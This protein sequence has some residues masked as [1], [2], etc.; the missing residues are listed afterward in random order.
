MTVLTFP[1][2]TATWCPVCHLHLLQWNGRPVQRIQGVK[3]VVHSITTIPQD[4]SWKA[5]FLINNYS[6]SYTSVSKI[7]DQDGIDREGRISNL[8]YSVCCIYLYLYCLFH[9]VLSKQQ[10]SLLFFL[11]YSFKLASINFTKLNKIPN[12]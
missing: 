5:S 9:I 8:E 12:T 6:C 3:G 1:S 11:W 4:H 2:I 7:S 10:S